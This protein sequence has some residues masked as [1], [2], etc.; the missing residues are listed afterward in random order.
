[1][2]LCE[3]H[4][5]LV[6]AEAVNHGNEESLKKG[7]KIELKLFLC[8]LCYLGININSLERNISLLQQQVKAQEK[9]ITALISSVLLQEYSILKG[10]SFQLGVQW[11]HFILI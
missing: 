1:M 2:V 4:A 5:Y 6:V 10:Y 7:G 3:M 9:T 8:A 11:R